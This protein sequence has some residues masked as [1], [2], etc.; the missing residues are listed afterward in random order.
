VGGENGF[1]LSP[2]TQLLLNRGIPLLMTELKDGILP[3]DACPHMQ[4]LSS[5]EAF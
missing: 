5:K 1:H 4:A 2:L 3:R